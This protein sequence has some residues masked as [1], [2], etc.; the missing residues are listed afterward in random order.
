[1]FTQIK[2]IQHLHHQKRRR[3]K[4]KTQATDLWSD[5][6]DLAV[7]ADMFQLRI[8]VITTKG[9]SDKTPTVSWITPDISLK[10]F[11]ELN[12]EMDDLVLLHEK[13]NHF[14]LIISRDCD[15]ARF[16][17]LTQRFKAGF[18]SEE[19]EKDEKDKQN[20][21]SSEEYKPAKE[22]DVEASEVEKLKT[23]LEICKKGK[24]FIENEYRKCEKELRMKTEEA[25][26][27]KIEI[28]D[29]RTIV[30]LRNE[31]KKKNIDVSFMDVEEDESSG[32]AE[33]LV[34]MK[35]TGF[36][37]GSP[38]TESIPNK[39]VYNHQEVIK[40]YGCLKCDFTASSEFNLRK[41]TELKH[42]EKRNTTSRSVEKEYNCIDC[43]F[44]GSTKVHLRKH[45]DLKHTESD[46]I[47]CRVCNEKFQEK[48]NLMSHRKMDHPNSVAPCKNFPNGMCS[49][50][51]ESCWWSH[52]DRVSETQGI[53]CFICGEIFVNKSEMMK[54]RKLIHSRIIKPCNNFANG[55][56]RYESKFCWFEHIIEDERKTV[57]DSFEEEI[58]KAEDNS[59]FQEPTKIPKP[60]S[61]P[62]EETDRNCI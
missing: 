44:Q 3:T 22:N 53:K 25:E 54:H 28:K 46:V 57:E 31:L 17:N 61:G 59:G 35:K 13:D 4:L 36:R 38:Q 43:D 52:G 12:V 20:S 19:N 34:D 33:L 62:M 50:T 37:K 10:E 32:D 55:N 42:H 49:F 14:N 6:E 18:I 58:K 29:L 1:M 9:P 15:L 8:K 24:A 27:F 30:K 40:Q 48:W 51:A 47:K 7:I 21:V 16:G 39:K 56:C 41:H 23:E 26:K 60:P 45:I 2:L 11:A 5:A